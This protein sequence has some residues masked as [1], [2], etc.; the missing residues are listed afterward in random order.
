MPSDKKEK[1]NKINSLKK[2]YLSFFSTRR[3][4]PEPVPDPENRV[5]GIS[6]RWTKQNLERTYLLLDE[7]MDVNCYRSGTTLKI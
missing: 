3:D 2:K 7:T 6:L 5:E 1:D 4:I